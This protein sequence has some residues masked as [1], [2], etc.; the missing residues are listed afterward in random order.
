MAPRP[1]RGRAAAAAAALLVACGGGPEDDVTGGAPSPVGSGGASTPTGSAGGAPSSATGG[2]SGGRTTGS[3]TSAGGLETTGAATGGAGTTGGAVSGGTGGSGATSAG[4]A[5]QATGAVGGTPSGGSGT[6]GAVA[7]T[8]GG[9]LPQAGAGGGSGGTGELPAPP[10]LTWVDGACPTATGTLSLETAEL[11]VGLDQASQTVRTLRPK[12]DPSFDFVPGDR[13]AQRSGPGYFHL[14]D[15]TLRWRS[16]AAGGWQ[17]TTTSASRAAVTAETPAGDVLAGADLGPALPVG[18]PLSITRRWLTVG[19]RLGLQFELT[20]TST[21]PVELGAVGLPMVFNNVI[22]DRSLEQAHAACSFADPYLGRDAGY[23]QVTRLSGRGPALLVLPNAG[24]P[25]EAWSPLLNAPQ[26]DS[27]DPVAIFTDATPRAQTFEGFYEWLAHSRAYVENEWS[28]AEPWNPPTSAVLAVGESRSY[29]VRLVLA[30]EIRQIEAMLAR[31]VRPVAVGIP[32]YV[33]PSDLEGKLYLRYPAAVATLAAEPAGALGV[34]ALPATASGWQAYDVRGAAAG[35]AR[36]TVTYADGTVQTVHYYVTPPAQEVLARLG[37]FLTTT[38]W[39]DDPSDPFGRSPS[40]LTYDHEL[41]EFVTQSNQAWVAGLGDDGG[42]T[43]LAGA[44]KLFGQP[45]ASE[46]SQYEAFVDGVVWGGLQYAAGSL[47]YGVKRSLFYYEPSAVPGG[48]YR[49]D[50]DWTYWG[51]WSRAH[52]L[53]VP[54]SYNYPHVAALYWSLYRLARNQVGL[55]AAHPWDFYLD[56]AYRTA[57]AMTTIGDEYARYG[58]MDGSV[59]R[60]ILLDLQREGWA[61]QAADLEDR[62]RARAEVWRDEAYPFGSEM[63]WDSTGQEEVYTWTR[64]FGFTEQARVC[65]DAITGYMPAIPHWGY[66]GCARRYWDFRYGGSKTRRLERMIHHY[67]SSLN[68]IPVLADFRDHPDDLHLLRIGY[69]GMMGT[70]TNVQADGFPSMAFHA[71]PDT[72]AWDPVSGD[73]GLAVF[74]HASG[75]ATYL[76][77]HPELGWQA[78]GGNLSI[79]GDTVRLTPLDSFRRRVYL[80][81]LGLWLT[82]DAGRFAAVEWDRATGE[83]RVTLA[84]PDEYTPVA[85]LRLEQPAP[86]ARAYA[87][88]ETYAQERGAYLVPLA[89]ATTV[90]LAPG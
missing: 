65:I 53:E 15:L 55:V 22:T 12:V 58:L 62:M 57:V 2:G 36:L 19:G 85:R 16:G 72:L 84:A 54:R 6:G 37:N 10:E 80:A 64:H 3:V 83:V 45:V 78:F 35:R 70:L 17:N 49:D 77:E 11:C 28:A 68:A 81:P 18:F 59:F 51:A 75:T 29:G 71:F 26:E 56:H 25:L 30:P 42:A 89:A 4:G 60:E 21:E 63:A 1:L 14:G 67:G 88:A 20:N 74:G 69:A 23:V 79:A 50:I 46:V 73:V 90:T 40:V 82:L 8:T 48:Y 44:M 9:S 41:G 47:Q 43:W 87:P 52:T 5:G 27:F 33:L 31:D 32:G 39:F 34:T 76:V 24:T 66:H 38:A 86:R 61:E 7:P 13:V